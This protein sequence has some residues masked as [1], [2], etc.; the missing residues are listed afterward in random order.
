MFVLMCCVEYPDIEAD[1]QCGKRNLVARAGADGARN[2]V[3]AGLAAS[4]ASCALAIVGGAV[5]TMALF[6]ALTLPAAWRL[7]EQ[8]AR[9]DWSG[10]AGGD[11]AGRG[12][13]FFVT[14]VLGSTLAYAA[15]L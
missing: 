5:P 12:V 15:V 14:T 8:L 7:V 2:L 10:P 9:G 1:L 3:Y 13:A 6:S 4:Y 11:I